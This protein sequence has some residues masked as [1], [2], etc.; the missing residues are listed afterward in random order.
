MQ[1][2]RSRVIG[3]QDPCAQQDN[4]GH[5]QSGR[6]GQRHAEDAGG[7][8]RIA[9]REGEAGKAADQTDNDTPVEGFLPHKPGAKS[10]KHRVEVENQNGETDGDMVEGR[11]QAKCHR[12]VEQSQSQRGVPLPPGQGNGPS[13]H[14]HQR[15]QGDQGEQIPDRDEGKR[16]CTAF[17]GQDGKGVVSGK[18]QGRG[19]NDYIA[20]DGGPLIHKPFHPV[21]A[22]GAMH[23]RTSGES[24]GY[25]QPR[26]HPAV[27]GELVPERLNTAPARLCIGQKRQIDTGRFN[28]CD[29]GIDLADALY[30]YRHIFTG[31]R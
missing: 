24:P 22:G 4:A 30:E 26:I 27:S 16:G 6:P 15:R 17:V 20:D 12:R 25:I 21:G 28:R 31:E 2:N 7:R 3:L 14:Q 9:E 5:Q 18:C 29:A 11:H 19:N 13:C 10:C 8:P 1:G 23:I